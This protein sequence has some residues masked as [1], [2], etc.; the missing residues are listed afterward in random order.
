[1]K[2]VLLV[3]AVFLAL[4]I[5]AQ[6]R[7][8]LG[9]KAGV[10]STKMKLS[11]IPDG[12]T[13][14]NEAKS[15]LLVGAFARLNLLGSLSVQPEIYYA[16]KQ[17]SYKVTDNSG[18]TYSE[19][20]AMHTWDIPLLVNLNLVDLKVAKIY[21]LAGPVA[22][23]ITKSDLEEFDMESTNW[24][25]QAGFGADIWKLTADFRYEWGMKDISKMSIGQKTDVFT[26][27]VG[28]KI[29]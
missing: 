6:D 1:M 19:T 10:N 18:T 26:F 11:D 4:N 28:F 15:G 8:T 3:V 12:E 27:S 9:I 24:T 20:N 29:L 13:V 21:G 7:F 23:F 22:S 25:F 2:Y 17:S 14:K 16:K 5:S